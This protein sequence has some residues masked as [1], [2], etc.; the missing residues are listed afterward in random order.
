MMAPPDNDTEIFFKNQFVVFS[1]SKIFIHNQSI[2][3]ITYYMANM[4]FNTFIGLF[5]G[6]TKIKL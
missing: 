4:D 6:I 1:L 2:V 3:C 5:I